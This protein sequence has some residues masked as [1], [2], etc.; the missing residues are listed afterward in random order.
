MEQTSAFEELLPLM[1]IQLGI[2]VALWKLSSR[3][4]MNMTV[5]V[6]LTITPGVGWFVIFYIFG[7]GMILILDRLDEIQPKDAVFT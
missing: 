6:L 1:L 4:E 7:K 5:F 3:V 2:L